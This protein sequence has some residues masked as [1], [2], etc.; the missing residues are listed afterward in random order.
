MRPERNLPV[1]PRVFPAANSHIPASSCARPPTPNAIPTTIFGVVTP[2]V[3]TLI[4]DRTRVVEAK[5]RKPL[6]NFKKGQ[7]HALKR[8]DKICGRR[9]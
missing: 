7:Y 6:V 1:A 2:R 4:K 8:I 9:E 5:D 3:E